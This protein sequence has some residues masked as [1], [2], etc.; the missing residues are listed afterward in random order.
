MAAAPAAQSLAPVFGIQDL[1]SEAE[2]SV[3]PTPA[4]GKVAPVHAAGSPP[5]VVVGTTGDPITPYTWA[6]ALASQLQHGVLLTRIGSGHTAYRDSSCIR[7]AVDKYL[8][9]LTPPA[10]GTSCPSDK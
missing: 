8:I 10:P 2:C 5:I 3:W 4:T 1:Y 6:Q 7:T 9:D